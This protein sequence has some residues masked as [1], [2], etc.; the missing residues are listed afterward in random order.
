[1]ATIHHNHALDPATGVLPRPPQA[2][3]DRYE[4]VVAQ[5]P[6]R[7]ARFSIDAGRPSPALLGSSPACD[8]RLTDPDVSRRHAALEVVEGGVRVQDLGSCNGTYANGLVIYDARLRSGDCLRVGSSLLGLELVETSTRLPSVPPVKS[9]GQLVGASVEMRRLYPLLE[10]LAA[11]TV[12]VLVEGETG[13]GKEVLAESLHAKGPR[14]SGPFVVFDCTAVAPTLLESSLF[15]H[16][17]GA[18]T[19]ATETRPGAFEEASGGTLLID[20]IADLD[21]AL[22]AK[23]LRAI[24]KSEVRRVGG[25]R[26]HRFDVRVLA[27]TRRDLDHE[28]QEGRFRDDLFFR[29]AVTRVELPPLRKR[30]GDVAVLAR[31]FWTALGGE[32]EPPPL[33]LERFDDYAWP[34]NVREL[35]NAVA[36]RLAL[37]DLAPVRGTR[38]A[39]LPPPPPDDEVEREGDLLERVLA[40]D[41]PLPRARQAVVEEF[42]RRYVD[43][44]LA[45]HGGNVARA[46]E[47][48]GIARRYFQLLR[49]RRGPTAH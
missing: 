19:G 41:L 44:V 47:A 23:L 28:V 12:P 13:T 1:M 11:S 43:R 35:R 46:A 33:L 45:R 29:I 10:R 34:G 8:V 25:S 6:E 27:A 3:G 14:A 48:S 31:H 9:F 2:L 49:S 26:W 15:G 42:E 20:E 4:L 37:G 16:E 32:G 38:N 21:I 40:R 18:F 24:E 39:T 22:Q 7:G 36:R 5:G 17:R 30:T